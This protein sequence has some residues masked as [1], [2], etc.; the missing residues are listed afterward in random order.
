MSQYE[1]F[2]SC[3]Q[4]T[5]NVERTELGE[6]MTGVVKVIKRYSNRKMY[7]TTHS[8]Y[9]TLDE[10]SEMVKQG[11][12][13]KIIDNKSG[14]DLTSVTLTQIIYEDQKKLS[15]ASPSSM[16]PLNALRGIIQSGN[17]IFQKLGTPVTKVGDDLKRRAEKLEEGR[18]EAIRDFIEGAQQTFKELDEKLRGTV[19]QMVFK[20]IPALRQELEETRAMVKRLE[21]ELAITQR[22]LDEVR[23]E[24]RQA[25]GGSSIPG[26]KS[27]PTLPL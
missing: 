21:I 11:E 3:R 5:L 23:S 1:G 18:Q 8:R 2:P 4:P 20:E 17:A 25:Q 22:D 7:D 19:E 26:Q 24:Q 9:I 12:D 10:I 16:L 27:N 6:D 13:L 15:D 14:A